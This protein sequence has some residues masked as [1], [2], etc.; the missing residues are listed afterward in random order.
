MA[1]RQS[2]NTE[3]IES[4]IYEDSI[5]NNF[6]EIQTRREEQRIGWL[7]SS[8]GMLIDGFTPRFDEIYKHDDYFRTGSKLIGSVRRLNGNTTIVAQSIQLPRDMSKEGI[9]TFIH[10]FNHTDEVSRT[11]GYVSLNEPGFPL[12]QPIKSETSGYIETTLAG[13]PLAVEAIRRHLNT[14]ESFDTDHSAAEIRE[15]IQ[16]TRAAIRADIPS[17]DEFLKSMQEGLERTR[18]QVIYDKAHPEEAAA[19]IAEENARI[20]E[21]PPID[22]LPLN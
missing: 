9:K 21:L 20:I 2:I 10:R 13:K 22:W 12:F 11:F 3:S 17:Y 8:P 18:Q 16:E 15:Q 6:M 5:N 19:R 14:P 1:E 7:V 4:E